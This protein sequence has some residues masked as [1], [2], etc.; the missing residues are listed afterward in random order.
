VKS[1]REGEP[2]IPREAVAS[3]PVSLSVAY[4][5]AIAQM[6]SLAENQPGSDKAWVESSLR[7]YRA[8]YARA[9]RVR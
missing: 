2:E 3:G 5:R 1:E 6:E 7:E 8:H 9:I 4:Q